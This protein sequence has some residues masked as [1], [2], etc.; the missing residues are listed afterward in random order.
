LLAEISV[1]NIA[2]LEDVQINFRKGLNVITGE[3]GAGKSILIESLKLALGEKVAQNLVPDADEGLVEIVYDLEGDEETAYSLES[4][5]LPCSNFLIMRRKVSPIGRSRIYVNDSPVTGQLVAEITSELV[6]ILGQHAYQRL[7]GSR[8]ATKL[9]DTFS[10]IL[11]LYNEYLRAYRKWRKIIREIELLK[12]DAPNISGRVEWLD[13]CIGELTALDLKTGEEREIEEELPLLKNAAKIREAIS[14]TVDIIDQNE[15]NSISLLKRGI[16]S[17]NSVSRFDPTLAEISLK[18]EEHMFAITDLARDL[19]TR[20]S[21]I[22]IDEEKYQSLTDRLSQ[23]K[24]LSR[25]Y[26]V[27]TDGLLRKVQDLQR[28]RQKI[29]SAIDSLN[30]LVQEEENL[31]ERTLNLA[32]SVR[33]K[34]REC[35]AEFERS[36][37]TEL[38][39]LG[40]AGAIFSVVFTEY[41]DS[42][43][44]TYGLE[45]VDFF[46]S[47]SS[48]FEG[49]PLVQVASGGE[50]SRIMLAVHNTV[51]GSEKFKT[52]IFDEVDAG[53]GGSMAEV[54]GEK[55]KRLSSSA[56]VICITHLPQIAA[57]ADH[58]IKIVK[59]KNESGDRT[60]AK[61]LGHGERVDEIARMVSGER[62]S[63][64]AK[65][66]AENLLKSG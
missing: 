65:K 39:D 46:F 21:L 60:V 44:S 23:L 10:K 11:P 52:L 45:R 55:L 14:G 34:R 47:P 24:R 28:E 12:E 18:L 48:S 1:K 8:N 35:A 13:A 42:E 64:E 59:V 26:E 53:I 15:D 27:Q 38:A 4:A 3:T 9:L 51:S 49:G 57:L 2:V 6:S 37:L 29:Q 5:G 62:I 66:Y 20:F 56:Q 30:N 36:V 54:I 17:L 58:H 31:K 50:L 19:M 32:R 61:S 33:E 41:D 7:F 16:D 40:L 43:L 25:K 22:D 63:D